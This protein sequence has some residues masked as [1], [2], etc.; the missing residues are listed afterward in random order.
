MD[1]YEI[2][3]VKHNSKGKLISFQLEDGTILDYN[4]AIEMARNGQIKNDVGVISRKSGFAFLRSKPD[5]IEE[6][7]LD[8]LPEF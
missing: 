6:N 3:A 1:Q 7:N 8:N 4:Q 5:G 2:V